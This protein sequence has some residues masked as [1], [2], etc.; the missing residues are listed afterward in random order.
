MF[1][2][3]LPELLLI[4]A[5][6]LVILGPDKLPRLARQIARYMGELKRA[7]EKL[8]SELDI[9]ESL[10]KDIKKGTGTRSESGWFDMVD[11]DLSSKRK[12]GDESGAGKNDIKTKEKK[13]DYSKAPSSGSEEKE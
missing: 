11:G 2:I 12:V 5:L 10:E 7:S 4:F 6:A 3:G 1:G 13:K 8:K 9:D